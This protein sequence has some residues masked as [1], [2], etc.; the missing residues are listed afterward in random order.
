MKEKH[1]VIGLGE[2]G[3]SLAKVFKCN[4]ED[5]FKNIINLD[6]TDKEAKTSFDETFPTFMGKQSS[7]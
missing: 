7:L 5:K 3:L 4:G 1:L 6:L 2:V